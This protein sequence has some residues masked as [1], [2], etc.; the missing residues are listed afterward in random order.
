MIQDRM[1]LA[2]E[3]K[4]KGGAK[5]DSQSV[6]GSCHSGGQ[7]SNREWKTSD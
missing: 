5:D 1:V 4:D 6:E 7:D 2:L 3:S